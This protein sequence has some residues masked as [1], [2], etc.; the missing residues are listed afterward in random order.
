MILTINKLIGLKVVTK[1]GQILGKIK[2]FE[3]NTDNS[4]IERFIVS[5]SDLVKKITS[6]NLIININQ[7]I[8]ITAKK[9]VVDDNLISNSEVIKQV[10]TT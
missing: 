7:V 4:K 9:M 5:S 1:S 6:Q 3:F 2:D 8:E 10:A